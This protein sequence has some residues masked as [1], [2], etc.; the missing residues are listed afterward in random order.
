MS[1]EP[2]HPGSRTTYQIEI[3]SREKEA[4]ERYCNNQLIAGD[5]SLMNDVARKIAQL[6]KLSQ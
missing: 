4:C 2:G 1:I 3:T 6:P 5:E